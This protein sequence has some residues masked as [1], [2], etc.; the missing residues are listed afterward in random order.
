MDIN[1]ASE[2][3]EKGLAKSKWNEIAEEEK[4]QYM[5]TAQCIIDGI[6][7]K[8][9]KNYERAIYEQ[10]IYMIMFGVSLQDINSASVDGSSISY[11]GT[12]YISPIAKNLLGK[13]R[14][15]SDLK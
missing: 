4:K 5:F 15:V 6:S 3:I 14:R 8:S 12:S 1:K 7:D 9:N 11:K 13:K 10:I 2:Y